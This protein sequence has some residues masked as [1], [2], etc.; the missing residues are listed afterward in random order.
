MTG[1][2]GKAKSGEPADA[3]PKKVSSSS[4]LPRQA[5]SFAHYSV[6]Q[7]IGRR[8]VSGDYLP[9]TILPNEAEWSAMFGTSR[10][11]VREAIKMLMSKNLL[12]SRTKIGSRV[13][14][15]ENWNHL[16][17]DVLT[18]VS[19]SPRRDALMR[20]VQ[21]LRHIV[22]PEA[23]ALAA[24]IRNDA[25]MAQIS[26]ACAEMGSANTL[27]QRTRADR[28][29]HQAILNAT[30]NELLMPLGAMIDS[31]LDYLFTFVT[32]EANDLRYAQDLHEAIE[33]AIRL[34]KPDAARM[35]VKALLRNTDQILQ[36]KDGVS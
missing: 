17:R 22:E 28:R 18:W 16:D 25:E 9:G 20:S 4:G 6:A 5:G 24:E 21:Q 11:V 19:Q 30:R 13:E 26:D 31:S 15:R 1:R 29:F 3:A 7:E 23:A 34:Q 14:P 33:R 12:V 10:S 2:Q 35:A 32:R 8:I 27:S 36:Q